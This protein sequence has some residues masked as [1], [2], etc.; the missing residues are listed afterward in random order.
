MSVV[1]NPSLVRFRAGARFYEE[2]GTGPVGADILIT[3]GWAAGGGPLAGGV[4]VTTSD[5]VPPT[6]EVEER[7]RD[8][9]V[10]SG[11]LDMASAPRLAAALRRLQE[12]GQHDITLDLGDLQFCDSSGLSVFVQAHRD[13]RTAGGRLVLRNPSERL[14]MLLTATQLDQELEIG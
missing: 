12:A 11:E 13:L 4:E 10:V 1:A 14:R 7:S 6:L 9:I 8:T 5:P 3:Y 2:F